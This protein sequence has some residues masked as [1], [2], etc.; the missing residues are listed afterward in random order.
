MKISTTTILE[1]LTPAGVRSVYASTNL[2]GPNFIAIV[3]EPST[4]AMLAAG[5]GSL[6]GFRRRRA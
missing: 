1:S 2:S 3:P 5:A 4:W 6:P